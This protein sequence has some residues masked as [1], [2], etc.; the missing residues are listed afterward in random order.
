M[1]GGLLALI[2]EIAHFVRYYSENIMK[3]VTGQQLIDAKTWADFLSG[4]DRLG[5]KDLEATARTVLLE[6]GFLD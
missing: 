3:F 4:L 1:R 6:A 5:A 2:G